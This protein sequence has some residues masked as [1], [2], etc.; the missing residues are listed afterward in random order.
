[1]GIAAPKF[2][3]P[4]GRLALYLRRFPSLSSTF[5]RALFLHRIFPRAGRLEEVVGDTAA[6]D[7]PGRHDWVPG[8]CMLVRRT[9]LARLGGFD[10]RFFMYC[11]DKDL[12]Q[13]SRRNRPLRLV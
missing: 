3:Y 6:Y 9:L 12:C 1:M 5:G 8:A 2:L 7:E 10:E 4:D 11:E 13:A